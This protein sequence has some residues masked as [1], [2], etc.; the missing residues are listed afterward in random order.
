MKVSTAATWRTHCRYNA[1]SALRKLSSIHGITRIL[2]R[3]GSFRSSASM[4]LPQVVCLAATRK[5]RILRSRSS[6]LISRMRQEYRSTKA[7][8]PCL[9]CL[10]QVSTRV[11][12]T[13]SSTGFMLM[14]CKKSTLA[15]APGRTGR[16][17]TDPRVSTWASVR[18]N[19]VWKVRGDTVGS[20]RKAVDSYDPE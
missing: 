11:Q 1:L 12:S 14:G 2:T 7:D 8:N 10:A 20:V 13:Y 4:S 6:H 17:T 19:G 16:W 3:Y 9:F 15:V 5:R 18:G